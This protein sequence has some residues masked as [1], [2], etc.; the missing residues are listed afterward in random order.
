MHN[1][2]DLVADFRQFY[3][4]DLPVC[5]I[6]EIEDIQ[7]F[8]R[9]VMLYSALPLNARCIR[10]HSP[11]AEWSTTDYLLWTIEFNI[12]QLMWSMLDKKA[13][14]ANRPPKPL[15]TPSERAEKFEKARR[16]EENKK[17]INEIL[18]MDRG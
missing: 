11:A 7:D 5:N 16:A 15:P 3:A 12:R 14:A 2:A 6:N 10:K 17:R 13:R 18:G 8:K 1:R 9:L 4:L